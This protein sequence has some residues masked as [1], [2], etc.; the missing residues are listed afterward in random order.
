MLKTKVADILEISAAAPG[1]AKSQ[2]TRLNFGILRQYC[3]ER[4]NFD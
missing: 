3:Y 1:V 2:I 4:G